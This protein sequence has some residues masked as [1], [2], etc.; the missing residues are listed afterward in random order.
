MA[1]RALLALVF[2]PRGGSAQVARYLSK[3]LPAAGWEATIACGSLGTVGEESNALTFY[4]GLDVRP[5]DLTAAAEAADPLRADPP[6][7]PSYEDREGAP[8]RVF[9]AVGDDDYERLVDTWSEHLARAG[10]ADAD[11]LHVHH[12]TPINEAAE[13]AF[14]GVP[15]VG[16][17]HGTEL[18]MLRRIDGGPPEGWDHAEAWAERMRRWA[19]SCARLFVLS[20][21]AV[22]R[23]PALLGVEPERVVWA[24]NGFDP[25]G[26][27]RRPTSAAGRLEHWRRWLVDEPR[28]WDTSGRPGSVAYA[29]G[30]LGPF[31]QG[32]VLLYVGR[33]TE[34][35]RIPLL[36]RAHARARERFRRA[37]PLVLLG[38]FPG[39]WEG[40]HPLE[41]VRE[42]GD[43]HV[44]LAGWR[45]HAD[46]PDGL[47]AADLLVLPS[48]REQFGQVLVE[49]MA[50][51]LPV[52]AVDAHGPAEIVR[53]GETGWLVSADDEEA[54]AD[55]LVEAVNGDHERRRRG[56]A[57]YAEAR[58][59]YSWPA[60]AREVAAVYDGV[61][62]AG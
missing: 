37:A 62:A 28:G 18:L 34:V 4:E 52:V 41:V 46:L 51:G 49:A 31:A 27:E 47:N 7:P 36:V 14:P 13:R 59:R 29:E 58:A 60:L 17:L 30:E 3:A 9:A 54:M 19:R 21:D 42:T 12:L 32:R 22:R 61:V 35:K 45:G 40:E 1:R 57:A 15:R 25:A 26:F 23:V 24:P 10:A 39:E 11:V 33:Y 8:D 56:E 53:D 43:D 2:F 44:F 38:G 48:V 55:A 5:L 20:P 16:H 6:F 50:C